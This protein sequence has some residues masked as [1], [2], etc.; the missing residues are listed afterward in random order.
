MK[1]LSSWLVYVRLRRQDGARIFAIELYI[2]IA[3]ALFLVV[4]WLWLGMPNTFAKD[5]LVD[6]LGALSTVLAGFFVAGLVAIATFF[7]ENS[8]LDDVIEH[9]PAILN[10]STDNEEYFTRR[11]YVCSIFGFLVGLSFFLAISAIFLR[12]FSE[13]VSQLLHEKETEIYGISIPW[14]TCVEFLTVYVWITV[15]TWQ[16]ILTL[17]GIYYLMDRIYDVRPSLGKPK[18]LPATKNE[19][20]PNVR[21]P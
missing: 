11:Q 13:P 12:S 14:H 9:G 3:I 4:A 21:I 5:G 17:R 18:N 15:F 20:G 7:R 8:S 2:S 10:Y 1:P 19:G 6:G 16:I